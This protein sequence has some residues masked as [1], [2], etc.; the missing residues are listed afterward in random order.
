MKKLFFASLF[1]TICACSSFKQPKMVSFQGVSDF[2]MKPREIRFTVS[3]NVLNPNKSKLK[4]HPS[5]VDV[6]LQQK[7][8]GKLSNE[9][10]I[11]LK[12]NGTS[13]ISIP[14]I[15]TTEKGALIQLTTLSFKDSVDVKFMGEVFVPG[16][17][18]FD[19][20][21]LTLVDEAFLLN[22]GVR[23]PGESVSFDVTFIRP[24]DG[25][26]Y[27]GWPFVAATGLFR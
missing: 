22:Y 14:L 11:I 24:V 10:K 26:V 23:F 2:K 6:Y 19:T 4:L 27:L 17:L 5:T 1:F 21:D 15:V 25:G 12:R 20:N 13:D 3:G 7:K 9:E 16:A 8:L 18:S